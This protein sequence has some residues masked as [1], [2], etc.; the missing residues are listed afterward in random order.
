M[1]SSVDLPQG[2]EYATLRISP[3]IDMRYKRTV[4]EYKENSVLSGVASI[5]GL[6]TFLGGLFAILFGSSII[7]TLFGKA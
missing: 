5:G 4:Q 6:W 1:R 3:V 7:R 2:P